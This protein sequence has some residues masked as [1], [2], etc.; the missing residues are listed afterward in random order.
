MSEGLIPKDD[1][2]SQ[3]LYFTG[4][5]F[6][7]CMSTTLFQRRVSFDTDECHVND[8][9]Q[10]PR[11]KERLIINH[12]TKKQISFWFGMFL[13]LVTACGREVTA[14]PEPVGA[15]SVVIATFTAAPAISALT[16]VETPMP[17]GA[18][19]EAKTMGQLPGLSPRNV[20][21]S[22]EEEQFTCTDVKKGRVYYERTCTRGVPGVRVF[23]VV[24]SGREPFLV[25]FIEASI[26]QYDEPDSK[27]AIPILGLLAALPHDGATPE[28]AKSWVENTIPVLSDDPSDVQENLFGG[29][30]YVLHGPHTAI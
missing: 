27:I 10:E 16:P 13:I 6:L 19:S 23:R 7:H 1:L 24:I 14:T 15:N 4:F 12:Q 3:L 26:L 25:D 30:K 28:E 22:L 8:T 18:A 5:P 20:T 29:V 17:T 21:V 2:F 9:L 11:R